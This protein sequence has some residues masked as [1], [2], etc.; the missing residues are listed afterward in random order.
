VE[1][2]VVAFEVGEVEL[3]G[4]VADVDAGASVVVV[5]EV[6]IIRITDTDGRSMILET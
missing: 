3:S 5:E 4:E 6:D 1:E 2:E